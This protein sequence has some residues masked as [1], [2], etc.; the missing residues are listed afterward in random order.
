MCGGWGSGQITTMGPWRQ[1]AEPS[2]APGTCEDT[3]R[4]PL[5]QPLWGRILVWPS[6]FFHIV[7]CSHF[8]STG[9][10]IF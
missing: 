2:E 1:G 9:P 4:P 7:I 5:P 6:P 10:Q 8:L 3:G